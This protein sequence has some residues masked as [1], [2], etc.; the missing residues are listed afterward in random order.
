MFG[1]YMFTLKDTSEGILIWQNACEIISQSHGFLTWLLYQKFCI[2]CCHGSFVSSHQMWNFHLSCIF[3]RI[4]ISGSK[5]LKAKVV[6]HP[7]FKHCTVPLKSYHP[8]ARRKS[9]LAIQS[10]DETLVSRDESLALRELKKTESATAWISRETLIV[11]CNANWKA[12]R[13]IA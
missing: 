6:S 2:H 10:R 1:H 8:L 12:H 3:S 11:Y 7:S 4:L 13:K 5:Q 9:R